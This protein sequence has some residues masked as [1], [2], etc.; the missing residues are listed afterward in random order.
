MTYDFILIDTC[1]L[2]AS[3]DPF[4][5]FQHLPNIRLTNVERMLAKCWMNGVFKRLQHHSTFL[6]TKKMLNRC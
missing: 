6:R 4:K 1:R 3:K 5:R 2:V